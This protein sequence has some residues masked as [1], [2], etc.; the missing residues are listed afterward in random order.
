MDDPKSA[1]DCIAHVRL[2]LTEP[3]ERFTVAMIELY[4]KSKTIAG[5]EEIRAIYQKV[6]NAPIPAA[7]V[8]QAEKEL[9]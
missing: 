1:A 4:A 3:E 7:E 5:M 9:P 6:F 2:L 8:V